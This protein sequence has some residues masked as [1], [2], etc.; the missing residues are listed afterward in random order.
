MPTRKGRSWTASPTVQNNPAAEAELRDFLEIRRCL[1]DGMLEGFS[2]R[3]RQIIYLHVTAHGREEIVTLVN[4]YGHGRGPCTLNT[5]N[6]VIETF[7]A[8][9]RRL[10]DED[11]RDEEG[12]PNPKGNPDNDRDERW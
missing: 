4:R 12:R 2:L 9:L 8:Q 6:H 10:E 1:D 5:V 3:D 11:E 7:Q